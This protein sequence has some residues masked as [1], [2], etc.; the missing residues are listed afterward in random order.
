MFDYKQGQLSPSGGS[1]RQAWGKRVAIRTQKTAIS[2]PQDPYPGLLATHQGR[3]EPQEA[4]NGGNESCS[5]KAHTLCTGT[6]R[7]YPNTEGACVD[8]KSKGVYSG[9]GV[10]P[11]PLP[12]FPLA[13][14]LRLK[15]IH[16]KHDRICESKHGTK[17]IPLAIL[18]VRSNGK[19]TVQ[20]QD[21]IHDSKCVALA[22]SCSLSKGESTGEDNS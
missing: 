20:M 8:V 9:E 7:N 3:I 11:A 14:P 21:G 10:F 22:L 17:F 18:P 6:G 12:P 5:S 16:V 1:C 13:F 2:T 4:P 15:S 19:N